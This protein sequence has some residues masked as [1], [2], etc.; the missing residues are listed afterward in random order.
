MSH[1]VGVVLVLAI[2]VPIP[3]VVVLI[4]VAVEQVAEQLAKVFVVGFFFK[5]E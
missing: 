2:A 3:D 5:F 4:V 1:L